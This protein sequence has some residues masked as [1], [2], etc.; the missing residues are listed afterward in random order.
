[1]CIRDSITTIPEIHEWLTTQDLSRSLVSFSNV[2]ARPEYLRADILPNNLKKQTLEKIQ[3]IP[4]ELTW[5]KDSIDI[6]AGGLYDTGMSDIINILN[7]D[8]ENP[9]LLKQLTQYLNSLDK[10]RNT[11]WKQTFPEFT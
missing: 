4:K 8:S 2:V 3:N 6:G 1:M 10:L 9:P 11:N 7:K 5:P